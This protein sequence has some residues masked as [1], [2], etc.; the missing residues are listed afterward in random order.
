MNDLERGEAGMLGEKT[1]R[2]RRTKN[3]LDNRTKN[4]SKNNKS[5]KERAKGTKMTK[6]ILARTLENYAQVIPEH[7]AIMNDLL[8]LAKG[9]REEGVE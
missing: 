9:I 7:W 1:K 2:R 3:E 5:D 8:E 4:P 6:E